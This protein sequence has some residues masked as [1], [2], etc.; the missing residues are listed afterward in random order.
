MCNWAFKF[1]NSHISP[2]SNIITYNIMWNNIRPYYVEMEIISRKRQKEKRERE[3]KPIQQ[4]PQT[5]QN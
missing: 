4:H 2:V 3:R 1:T 5:H